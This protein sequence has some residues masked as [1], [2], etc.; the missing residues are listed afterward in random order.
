MSAA[1]A[2]HQEYGRLNVH[3]EEQQALS[4]LAYKDA[5]M[6]LAVVVLMPGCHGISDAETAAAAAKDAASRTGDLRR[7]SV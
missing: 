2:M 1:D 5:I 4:A 6:L 3:D 7:P